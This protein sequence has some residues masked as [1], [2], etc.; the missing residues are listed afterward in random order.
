MAPAFSFA[1][2]RTGHADVGVAQAEQIILAVRDIWQKELREQTD[3]LGKIGR[4]R[5][6]LFL[7]CP[8]ENMSGIRKRMGNDDEIVVTFSKK[9]VSGFL[10][11]V[12]SFDR[13]SKYTYEFFE[14]LP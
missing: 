9:G 7:T 14:A 12:I 11:L 3:E 2:E 5:K 1:A 10:S 13:E 6:S 4:Q 8:M